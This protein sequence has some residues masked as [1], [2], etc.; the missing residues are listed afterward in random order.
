MEI[1]FF[2]FFIG[3]QIFQFDPLF[4]AALSLHY[5]CMYKFCIHSYLYC[6]ELETFLWFDYFQQQPL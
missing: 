5:E 3:V 2:H 4:I 6:Y 1:V